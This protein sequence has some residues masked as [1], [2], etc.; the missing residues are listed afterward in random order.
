L[1]VAGEGP[2]LG[3]LHALAERLELGDHVRFLGY[4]DRA[5]ALRDCYS[6]ADV[7]VFGSTT[8]TQGLVLL[9]AMAMGLPTVAVPAMGTVD[10]LGPGRGCV[11]TTVEAD[12]FAADLCALLADGPRRARLAR[13]AVDYV[14]TVWAASATARR[15]AEF[16]R[17]TLA[18]RI[19]TSGITRLDTAA[20]AAH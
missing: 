2:A 7:F 17:E 1:L 18:R 3:H 15:L 9:E 11:A 19:G 13:D 8:E 14:E 4:L 20:S 6:A 10:I 16:Y 5:T 12:R